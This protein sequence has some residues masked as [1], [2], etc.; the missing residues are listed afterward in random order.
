MSIHTPLSAAPQARPVVARAEGMR[1]EDVGGYEAHRARKG[2]DLGHVDGRRSHLNRRLIGDA[3]WATKAAAE[4]AAM[5]EE[6]FL[7]EIEG[8]KRRKRKREL[9][10][11]FTEGP[12]DPFRPSRHGPMREIILTAHQ[13][14]FAA[15]SDANGDDPSDLERQFEETAVTWLTD[16]FGGDVVHARADRDESAYH[17]HAVILPR[18]ETM[19]NGAPRKLLQPSKFEVIQDYE[20]L[21]DSVGA[22]F[23][24]LGLKRGERRKRAI[25]EALARGE[26]PPANPRHV[27]PKQWRRDQERKIAAREAEIEV[28]ATAV[29]AREREV[30]R[31]EAAVEAAIRDAGERSAEADAVLAL[32]G[33]VV[34]GQIE[35]ADGNRPK[36]TTAADADPDRVRQVLRRAN[37]SPV[38]KAKALGAL[39]RVWTGLKAKAWASALRLSVPCGLRLVGAALHRQTA[40]DPGRADRRVHGLC[41]RKHDRPFGGVRRSG[42]VA[43]LF[44]A[45]P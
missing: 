11:R 20:K 4:I 27:R 38:G 19:V 26:A 42:A 25:R 24:S 45:W 32:V 2:G 18:V 33:A 36:L 34:D 35:I 37:Q 16:T 10:K 17:I 7:C 13:D 44:G 29:E 15:A 21:Q 40:S 14:W 31:R 39:A 5:R 8:L 23:A 12:K 3:D 22:A 28:R 41:V 43:C 1:P 6:N 30:I 9:V